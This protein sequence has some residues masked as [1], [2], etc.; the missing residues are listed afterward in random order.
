LILG[1]DGQ[2]VDKRGDNMKKIDIK[3]FDK[4]DDEEYLWYFCYGSNINIKRF[5]IY[6]NGDEDGYF[7]H[8]NGC[9]DK[10][11]PLDS[12]PYIIRRRIYFARHSGKWNGG[13]AFLNYRSLGKVYGKIYKI[14]KSQFMD[15]LKQEHHLKDYNTVIYIGKYNRVPIYTFTSL[16]KLNDLEKPSKKY[17]ETIKEGIKDTYKTLSNKKIDK[18]LSKI[19]E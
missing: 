17:L 12:K 1:I 7:A 8:V 4:I 11:K 9:K 18:Y 3:Y 19:K 2:A 13:V 14:K 15:I 5:M 16:Y 10:T 6:I